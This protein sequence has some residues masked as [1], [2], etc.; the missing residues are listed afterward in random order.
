[1]KLQQWPSSHHEAE[2]SIIAPSHNV[3]DIVVELRLRTKEAQKIFEDVI[4][5]HPHF[6]LEHTTYGQSTVAELIILEAGYDHHPTL[7]F[8]KSITQHGS[9]P[10][11]FLTSEIED[12]T[13]AAQAIQVGVQDFFPRPL[14]IKEITAA[15]DRCATRRGRVP[16]KRRKKP[17]M[18]MSFF[19]GR[20]G[21]GTTTTAVNF[22]VSL[23]KSDKA[24]SV[25]LLELN[26]HAGDLALF[27]NVTMPHTLCELGGNVLRLDKASLDRFLVKHD[28]GLHIISSGYTDIQAT[29]FATEWIAP[30]ITLL[31][32]RF[33]FVLIDCG[34]TLDANTTMAF[35]LSATIFVLSTLTIPIVKR[36]QLVLEYLERAGIPSSKVQWVLNRYIEKE[37]GLLKET[38]KIFHHQ[39][40]WIIPNDYPMVSQAM[41]TGYPLV[42]TFPKSAI[43]KIFR[44]MTLPFLVN[45]DSDDLKSSTDDGWVKRIWSKVSK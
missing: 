14:Q 43:A 11:V 2:R 13:L 37:N 29:P 20:G 42:E 17:R 36:T 40:S 26:H 39:T 16:K 33:D 23:Q 32:T 10:D 3:S 5:A 18:V 8:I 21:I 27:L 45:P 38:E 15:L 22:G 31:K 19:G 30:I 34:H 4:A 25:V 44:N 12:M 41:N 6:C 9:G 7:S 24:P 1:M 28:S 35:G